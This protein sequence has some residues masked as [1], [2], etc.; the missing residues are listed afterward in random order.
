MIGLFGS[1]KWL[2]FI[3]LAL[4]LLFGAEDC[5]GQEVAFDQQ[6]PVSP[7]N[8]L[9]AG[10]YS[11]TQGF[12][13]SYRRMNFAD[14][15]LTGGGGA[16]VNGDFSVRLKRN[17]VVEEESERRVLPAANGLAGDFYRFAFADEA[18]IFPGDQ[19]EL[20]LVNH[21]GSNF[22]GWGQTF[23]NTYAG[24]EPGGT[25]GVGTGGD[26]IFRTG[27]QSIYSPPQ[28]Q[29]HGPGYMLF[30]SA[31][32]PPAPL[33]VG[34]G[35]V[36]NSSF[37]SG[38]NFEITAT[39]RLT[40][41]GA[42]FGSTT[43]SVFGALVKTTGFAGIPVPPNLSGSD[44]RATT[45]ITPPAGGG[46]AWGDVDV[47]L[48]P[49]WYGLIFGSGK[50]GA[51]G[52]SGLRAQPDSN[53]AWSPYSIRQSD[54][55]RFF[56]ATDVRIFAEALSTSGTMQQRPVFDARAQKFGSQWIVIDGE[57]S[58]GPERVDSLSID[59][60]GLMEFDLSQVPAGAM[61]TGAR[62]HL[63]PN[64]ITSGGGSGPRL[65]V[66]GY[67][68]DGAASAADPASPANQ[69]G[70]TSVITTFAPI[71]IDLSAAYVQSLIDADATHLGLMIRP[72][73]NG[74]RA[75]YVSWEGGEPSA[76][77]LL[78][79]DYSLAPPPGDFDAN[80]Q[81]NADDLQTWASRFG[82]DLDGQDF[83]EWQRE[84]SGGGGA[85]PAPEPASFVVAVLGT[86]VGIGLRGRRRDPRH[87]HDAGEFR[88]PTSI[89]VTGP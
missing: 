27:M 87:R 4:H 28:A 25:G 62:L 35:T 48:E 69:I 54:G 11:L 2:A 38:L 64:Q 72:D 15:Y 67:Q 42:Y 89:G 61:I 10:A 30:E 19:Y 20:E 71:T 32:K 70:S 44:V 12:K 9:N 18:F 80:G 40:K 50:F 86:A 66:H 82:A 45:V 37:F 78:T 3:A 65:F 24:G 43:G 22:F 21:S 47:T 34:G 73:S 53:G 8:A 85:A 63:E 55:Q 29:T 26:L 57:S 33:P 1:W 52:S 84:F 49:G 74:H 16:A 39:T 7:W 36:V 60:R 31:L 56:Q 81:V 17:G 13:P 41:V 68:G 79:I 23:D 59:V 5:C 83:L 88:R 58:V 6:S 51:S 14:I 46:D 76:V 77:P 75:H